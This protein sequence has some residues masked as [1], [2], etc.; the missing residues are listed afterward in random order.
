MSSIHFKNFIGNLDIQYPQYEIPADSPVFLFYKEKGNLS[1]HEILRRFY[2]LLTD[3]NITYIKPIKHITGE[4]LI[5]LKELKYAFSCFA[6]SEYLTGRI[7]SEPEYFRTTKTDEFTEEV[8]YEDTSIKFSI[9]PDEVESSNLNYS[10]NYHGEEL[11]EP[12]RRFKTDYPNSLRCGFLMMKFEDTKIQSEIVSILKEYFNSKGLTLLRADDKWYADDL[13]SNIKTYMHGCSF[14]I[15]LFE[16]INSDYFNP[17][18]SLEIGYMMA[19]N[20]PILFLKERTL[21]S[22][23]TDLIGKLYYEYDFQNAKETLEVVVNKWIQDKE[24][25]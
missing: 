20:K 15:A 17:N 10:N 6:N 9:Y 22:L 7:T 19:L 24:I 11:K 23:H 21:T 25:I 1:K 16:R 8:I 18:V 14:G 5:D 4:W 2:K 13:F 12:L 3:N